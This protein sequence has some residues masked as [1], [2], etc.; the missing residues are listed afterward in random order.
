MASSVLVSTS[1]LSADWQAPCSW[2]TQDYDINWV[3][4]EFQNIFH[5]QSGT[6]SAADKKGER[7]EARS[8]PIEYNYL[9]CRV[10]GVFGSLWRGD[11]RSS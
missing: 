8:N 9:R 5:Y 7:R 11:Y 6:D 2:M 3:G 1:V 4:R 10:I